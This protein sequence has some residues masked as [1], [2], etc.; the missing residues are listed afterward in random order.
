MIPILGGR[1]RLCDGSGR[2]E[3]LRIGG[4]GA[5]GLSLPRLLE[6]R[7]EA[8]LPVRAKRCILFFQEGG[9]AHQDTVDPKP[10]APDGAGGEFG[11]IPTRVP[12]VHF[13]E[14][15]PLLART[16]HRFAVVRSVSH[17]VVDHNA[18]AYYCLS[19][20]TPKV[21]GGLILGDRRTNF[22]GIGAV[23]ARLRPPPPGV[24]A[25]V[26]CPN[27]L[28]N[29]NEDLPGQKAGW[30]GG[31]YDPLVVADPTSPAFR[32]SPLGSGG[33]LPD[34]RLQRRRTLLHAVQE[35]LEHLD[36]V[37]PG[38]DVD[39]HYARAFE[40]VTSGA[41]RA[42]CDLSREGER[43]HERYGRHHMGQTFLLARRLSEAGVPLVQVCWGEN[44]GSDSN[45][46]WDTHRRNFHFLK[47]SLLPP[48]DRG[49]SALIEDL[50]ERGMLE[51]TLVVAM[52]E[53]GR[54]PE[55]NKQGGRDHW[56]DCYSVLLA[57]GG[58]RGGAVYGASDARAAY[59]VSD[60]VGPEDIAATIFA[61]LGLNPRTE[62]T[63]PLGRP[64]PIALG[65]PIRALFG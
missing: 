1:R 51:E 63:D 37:G 13:T 43:V 32:S 36:R 18:G 47:S 3:L 40:L 21:A 11:T 2:R 59:P 7:A 10:D 23:V 9:M 39:G 25:F 35:H 24:P 14:H 53:F 16:N 27:I 5:L 31:G 42:A 29:N 54:T 57:G 46:N 56:P 60:R 50:D 26:H 8:R 65:E 52:G 33:T 6:G 28:Y 20:R 15:L 55:I 48:T 61:A 45:Q 17:D 64:F 58:I 22:P 4:L 34:R 19:G 44:S 38:R 30:L 12:G 62:I 49:L 41:V